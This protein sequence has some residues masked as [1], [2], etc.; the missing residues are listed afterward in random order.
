M[1]R[2]AQAMSDE[3]EE[4]E[5]EGPDLEDGI[6]FEPGGHEIQHRKPDPKRYVVPLAGLLLVSWWRLLGCPSRRGA[7]LNRIERY[8]TYPNPR[9]RPLSGRWEIDRPG[10]QALRWI[11]AW[12]L[13]LQFRAHRG[14][15]NRACPTQPFHYRQRLVRPR[16]RRGRPE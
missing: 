16:Y 5:R 1:A 13:A 6:D 14:L 3:A 15:I 4:L 12:V 2:P 7:A 10:L 9:V 11:P 8:S